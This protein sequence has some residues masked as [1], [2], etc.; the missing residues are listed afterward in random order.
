MVERSEVNVVSE[1]EYLGKLI[2][3]DTRCGLREAWDG[4]LPANHDWRYGEG[5]TR[6]FHRDFMRGQAKVTGSKWSLPGNPH[7]PMTRADAKAY[8]KALVERWGV[9]LSQS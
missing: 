1:V 4:R 3:T 7:Q 6:N 9:R 2:L 8:E 5:G